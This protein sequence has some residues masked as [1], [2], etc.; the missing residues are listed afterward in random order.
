MQL[1]AFKDRAH[2]GRLLAEVLMPYANRDDVIV[3]AL[4]RGG[5]PVAYEVAKKLGAPLDV[6]VVRKLGV[7]G[8]EELAMGAIAS[9]GIRVLN[10]RVIRSHGISDEAIETAVAQQTK[11]LQRR[12]LAYRGH[13]GAPTIRD[14][15][16]LLV[17]DG[18]ATGSTI[19][20]AVRALRPQQP[21]RIVIAVPISAP[22]SFAE[23]RPLVD[24][25]ITL[26][27]PEDFCA[28]GQ[29]YEDF[30]QT[31]DD[32]VATLMSQAD[33]ASHPR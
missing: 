17:D 23:L 14:K 5:V 21:R 24:D 33:Q 16:V 11:E 15:T 3:L 20:A 4:P 10:E 25:L 7:P 30:S 2:A 26:M 28:V 18:I 19:R 29:C 12:E 31:T 22:D 8:W 13:S 6:L 32:E 9:G 27:L 1:R